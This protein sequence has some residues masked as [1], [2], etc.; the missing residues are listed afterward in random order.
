MRKIIP[1]LVFWV[2]ILTGCGV[3]GIASPTPVPTVNLDSGSSSTG[4][5]SPQSTGNSSFTASGSLKPIRE[6]EIGFLSSN[7]VSEVMVNIGDQVKTGAILAK[8]GGKEQAQAAVSEAELQIQAAQEELD[9][10]QREAPEIT[11]KAQTDLI[12]KDEDLQ[13]A[14]DKVKYL[15]HLDWLRS[16]GK[17]PETVSVSKQGYNYPTDADI[18]KAVAELTLAQAIYDAAA[19]HMDDVQNGPEPAVLAAAQAKLQAAKDQKSAAE[20]KLA[21]LDIKAPFDGVVSA[22]EIS[23]GDLV[24]PGEVLFIVTD[25]S[26]LYVETTDL[27]ERDAP[28]VTPGQSVGV[29]IKALSIEVPGKVKVISP[30]ADTIGGDVVY[31]VLVTLDEIPA[32]A[33][34]GM[35]VEVRFQ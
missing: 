17:K 18:A 4:S 7:Y 2:V 35:S 23:T 33:L 8:I 25:N 10:V 1:I 14:K 11:A 20:A 13:D 12:E 22:M 9:K 19:A 3:K 16:Q 29:W 15:K 32:G 21:E 34:S 26:E 5:N 6:A 30:R 24:T 31:E 27:S 28:S